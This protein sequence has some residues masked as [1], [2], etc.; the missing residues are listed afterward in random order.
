MN[1]RALAVAG[2]MVSLVAGPA[3][4]TAIHGR[5]P[6]AEASMDSKLI[7][8]GPG[9]RVQ[10]L[11]QL[12]ARPD[13]ITRCSAF[14]QPLRR[15]IERVMDRPITWVDERRVRGPQFWVLAPVM[16]GQESASASMAWWD[17]GRFS[18]RG[19]AS[20]RFER[21]RGAW[22]PVEGTAWEGCPAT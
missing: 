8:T 15:A 22:S 14:P 20:L 19:G 12:C 21:H 2:V 17:P 5:G 16:F 4:A 3:S 11:T 9:Q 7:F 18:C 10:V 1:L 13:R 6:G